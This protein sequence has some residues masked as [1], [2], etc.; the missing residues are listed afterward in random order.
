[1]VSKNRFTRY[2]IKSSLC[3]A[4]TVVD[5]RAIPTLYIMFLILEHCGISPG[6]GTATWRR[7]IGQTAGV[8]VYG[9][10]VAA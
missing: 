4:S 5:D 2:R 8:D 9:E 3:A 7:S 10:P 6:I 1:M